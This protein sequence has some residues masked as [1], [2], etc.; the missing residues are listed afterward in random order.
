MFVFFTNDQKINIQYIVMN[1]Q[2][3]EK[4]F[5]NIPN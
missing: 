5:L 2:N 3:K 4:H 1:S